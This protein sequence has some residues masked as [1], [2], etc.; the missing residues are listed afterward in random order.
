MAKR[1][2][3]V[4]PAE[5]DRKEFRQFL[6]KAGYEVAQS[7]ARGAG[8]GTSSD[9]FEPDLVLLDH[10]ADTEA[11]VALRAMIDAADERRGVPV[12]EM[13]LTGPDSFH[14]A[15]SVINRV[16]PFGSVH[17]PTRSHDR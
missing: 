6:E 5:T 2:L 11:R 4:T 13:C 14:L 16:S 1:L 12:V 3:L 10:E 7:T 9:R 15:A 8:E 17:R